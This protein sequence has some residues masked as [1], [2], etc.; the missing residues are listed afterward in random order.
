M[1]ER[2][3]AFLFYVRD[4]NLCRYTLGG[5]KNTKQHP[6]DKENFPFSFIR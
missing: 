4:V 6:L 1:R 3:S 5:R 2:P